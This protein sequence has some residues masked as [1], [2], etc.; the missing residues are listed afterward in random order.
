[1]I[2]KERPI[3]WR[4][5]PR[6]GVIVITGHRGEGKSALAWWLAQDIQL[7]TKPKKKIVALG[8]PD[9][10]KKALPR[11]GVGHVNTVEEVADL[12]PS[13][14]ILDEAAFIANSRRSQSTQNV[15]WLQLIAIC[16]HKGHLLI[17]INQ[18]N[19]QLDIQI[20][21]DAD[22]VIMKRPTVLHL[23]SCRAEFQPELKQAFEQFN[24]MRGN[25]KKK[26]FVVDYHSGKA[27]MLIARMPQW[28]NDKVSKAYG[29]ISLNN[30]GTTG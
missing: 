21:A 23:R 25:T 9:E 5:I 13:I 6:D 30:N 1:L 12:K 10:A 18:H 3:T 19:R 29:S 8:M 7:R 27:A 16:R 2:A 22:Y 15:M 20:L 17:F 24:T 28:W 11:R 26:A 4:R 14:V